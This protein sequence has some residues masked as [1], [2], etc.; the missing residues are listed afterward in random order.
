MIVHLQLRRDTAANWAAANPLLLIGE[1][2]LE[3]DT[4]QFKI[5]NGATAW[6][7]LAYGGIQ[8][9]AGPQG[10]DGSA[11]PQGQDGAAGPQGQD[12]AAGPAGPMGSLLGVT[13]ITGNSHTLEAANDGHM[14]Y[15][16]ALSAVTISTAPGLGAAFSAMI[17]QGGT[18]QVTVAQGSGTTLA[19]FGNLLKTAGRY[20]A[21]SVFTPVADTFILTGQTS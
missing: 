12:G 3:T 10:Q 5:G 14:L 21:I 20:A 8:G 18:G 15:C 19:S 9:S 7:S 17:I 11:G 1:L 13:T 16:T 2:G 6:N 4:G